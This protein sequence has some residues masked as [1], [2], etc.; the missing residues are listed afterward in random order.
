MSSDAFFQEQADPVSEEST[1]AASEDRQLRFEA[2]Q[3]EFDGLFRAKPLNI[4]DY[5]SGNRRGETDIKNGEGFNLVGD[6]AQLSRFPNC[7]ERRF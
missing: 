4:R 1:F 2:R 3:S 6:S 7:F 5:L